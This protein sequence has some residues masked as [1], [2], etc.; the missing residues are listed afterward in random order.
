MPDLH[1]LV[2]VSTAS[3]ALSQAELEHLLKRARER[4]EQQG[5]TGVL[6]YSHGNFM[7]YLEGTAAGLAKIYDVIKT[8]PL[9]HGIIELLSEP[10]DKREFAEWS[11]AFRSISAYGMSHPAHLGTIFENSGG[12]TGGRPS[13]SYVLLAKFWNKGIV[14]AALP[15]A[16]QPAAPPRR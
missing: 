3:R 9:H 8:D 4:N 5:V 14:P 1:A 11:M 6:L 10:I 12:A 13:A 7:Q 15:P 16:G 2:Y